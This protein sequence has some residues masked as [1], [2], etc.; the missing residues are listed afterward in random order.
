MLKYYDC[1]IVFQEIPEEITLAIEI[2]GC[3]HRCAEC[4]SPWLREDIGT[5]LTISELMKLI[6]LNPDITCICFMG[7]DGRH[8]HIAYL[9]DVI[10]S[11]TALKVAMYSGDKKI[12]NILVEALDYYK[13]GPYQKDKGPLSSETTNQKLYYIDKDK[14][15]IDITYKMYQHI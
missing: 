13:I 6:K 11:N 4:H 15:L 8:N 3:P 14:N 5:K 9:A 1:A 10:H 12:D 7:G 2:T